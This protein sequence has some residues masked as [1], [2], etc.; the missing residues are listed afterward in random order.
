MFTIFII[1]YIIY[2]LY[3]VREGLAQQYTQC[4]QA[5]NCSDC[6]SAYIT[7]AGNICSWDTKSGCNSFGDGSKFCST[8]STNSPASNAA[9]V[10][11][12]RIP[13]L[14]NRK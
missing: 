4:T 13:I 5:K 7:N 3:S 12:N 6:A 10:N 8:T 14:K 11:N 1:A 2:R 9:P